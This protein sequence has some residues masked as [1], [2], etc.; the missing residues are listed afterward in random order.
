MPVGLCGGVGI[1]WW[2]ESLL[3][4]GG[5]LG[6]RKPWIVGSAEAIRC[7]AGGAWGV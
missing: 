4:G 2:L 7:G 1:G 5:V 6:I 3:A